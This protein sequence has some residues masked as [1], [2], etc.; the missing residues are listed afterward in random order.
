MSSMRSKTWAQKFPHHPKVLALLIMDLAYTTNIFVFLFSWDSVSNNKQWKKTAAD[1]FNQKQQDFSD[2]THLITVGW[3]SFVNLVG[4]DVQHCYHYCLSLELVCLSLG[5]CSV[6]RWGCSAW[7]IW[8]LRHVI[9]PGAAFETMQAYTV[10]IPPLLG[11]PI[12]LCRCPKQRCHLTILSQIWKHV[13]FYETATGLP[14]WRKTLSCPVCPCAV[15]NGASWK[16]RKKV[17]KMFWNTSWSLKKKKAHDAATVNHWKI[18]LSSACI[19]RGLYVNKF[20][21]I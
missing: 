2:C 12:T 20:Y 17:N 11:Q 10:S 15:K 13:Y 19:D 3:I 18:L 5:S 14:L 4:F 16:M 6:W 21:T 8:W 1:D 9:P 7:S